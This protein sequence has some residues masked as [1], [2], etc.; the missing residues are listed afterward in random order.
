MTRY[1][2][3]KDIMDSVGKEEI[4]ITSTGLI[5]R[6]VYHY[7]DR[8]L[9][10]YM[11]GSMGNALAIG[12]GLAMNVKTNVT[13]INGDAS[14]LMSLGTTATYNKIRPK[15]L[16]H[17]ILDNKCHESTGGQDSGAK[18]FDLDIF[19]FEMVRGDFFYYEIE[20]SDI[21]PPRIS[22]PP[23]QI[24]KRFKN[25]ISHYTIK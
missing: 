10:F 4:I 14:Y 1:D 17:Y 23:K 21:I 3:V 22:M 2:I 15:N 7:K 18:N 16:N 5:S 25:A 6:E 19:N 9:N 24:T 8:P 11:M 13:V 20:K 12:L